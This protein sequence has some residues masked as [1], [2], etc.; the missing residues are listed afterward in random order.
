MKAKPIQQVYIN[1]KFRSN[2]D[3][4]DMLEQIRKEINCGA[5]NVSSHFKGLPYNFRVHA[6]EKE[7]PIRKEIIDNYHV[8]I[9]QSKLNNDV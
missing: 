4:L 2:K 8:Q 6:P 9:Y 5:R 3:V 7:S 1:L